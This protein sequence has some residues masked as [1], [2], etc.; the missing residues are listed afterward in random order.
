MFK[1]TNMTFLLVGFCFIIFLAWLVFSKLNLDNSND[2]LDDDKW[3]EEMGLSV[4]IWPNGEPSRDQWDEILNDCLGKEDG[5]SKARCNYLLEQIESFNDC[6]LAGFSV[7][8]SD[9]EQ[10]R[11]SDDRLFVNE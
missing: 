9:P 5:L 7:M 11:T 3:L 6:V 4:N 2:E 10:C 8:E 1:G